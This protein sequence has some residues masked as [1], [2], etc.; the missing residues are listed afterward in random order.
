VDT[1]EAL[2][3]KAI[4]GVLD[5][6]GWIIAVVLRVGTAVSSSHSQLDNRRLFVAGTGWVESDKMGSNL[7][8]DGDSFS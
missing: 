6:H 5:G 4:M 8:R 3:E 1:A 2:T 7:L